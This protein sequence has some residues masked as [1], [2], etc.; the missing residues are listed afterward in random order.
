MAELSL[1]EI[2][3]LAGRKIGEEIGYYGNERKI[4]SGTKFDIVKAFG[5]IHRNDQRR[6][7][8]VTV[9]KTLEGVLNSLDIIDRFIEEPK[10]EEKSEES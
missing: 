9:R 3:Y 6:D 8:I 5:Q 4:S 1:Q 7:D 10:A 2:D